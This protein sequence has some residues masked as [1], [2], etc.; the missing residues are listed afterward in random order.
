MDRG[1]EWCHT[2]KRLRILEFGK[3]KKQNKKKKKQLRFES[4]GRESIFG[5]VEGETS[6]GS[7]KCAARW[8]SESRTDDVQS[9]S[10][11]GNWVSLSS[12]RKILKLK[13]VNKSFVPE[14]ISCFS[15]SYMRYEYLWT[16]SVSVWIFRFHVLII[17]LCNKRTVLE[18]DSKALLFNNY[19]TEVYGR[20]PLF[21]LDGSTLPLISTLKYWEL[22]KEASSS[23]FQSFDMTQPN[24]G[25]PVHW[26]TLTITPEHTV[27]WYQITLFNIIN[28]ILYL[29]FV[30]VQLNE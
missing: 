10:I 24:P 28:S 21:F 25:L 17:W 19:Y 20:S 4:R 3:K 29:S 6:W 8:V 11:V 16:F 15:D 18:N 23:I 1:R 7:M 2:R 30:C 14:P 13:K 5:L 9:V 12:C 22:S 27:K 26:Q